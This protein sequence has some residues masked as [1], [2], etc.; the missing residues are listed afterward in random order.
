MN[1]S[2]L[3]RDGFSELDVSN[4]EATASDGTVDDAWLLRTMVHIA[5]LV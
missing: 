5:R 2:S 3:D 4:C 1:T